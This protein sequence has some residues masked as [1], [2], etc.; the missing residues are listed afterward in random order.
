MTQECLFP[1]CVAK[2]W[3]LHEHCQA[4]HS[5]R[6]TDE[7]LEHLNAQLM[8]QFCQERPRVGLIKYCLVH[9]DYE[10]VIL[11]LSCMFS[12][13]RQRNNVGNPIANHCCCKDDL[14][15]TPIMS[16]MLKAGAKVCSSLLFLLSQ[17]LTQT[18]QGTHIGVYSVSPFLTMTRRIQPVHIM[19]SRGQLNMA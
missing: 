9:I 8:C 6:V 4:H 16:L 10:L 19:V 11:D 2:R 5:H 12:G 7:E 1:G 14:H 3:Y 15:Q 13:R 18:P 17:L